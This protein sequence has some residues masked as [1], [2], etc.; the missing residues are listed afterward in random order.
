MMIGHHSI[1]VI[2]EAVLKGIYVPR[3]KAKLLSLLCS[4]A[5]R[6]SYR[7]L[8]SYQRLGYVPADEEE[9]SVSKTLEYAYDD[10]AIARYA[11]W[12]GDDAVARRYEERSGAWRNVWSDQL[13]FF[14]P[15]SEQAGFLPD[16]YPFSFD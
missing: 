4:T 6:K 16:F 7:G 10:A 1:P 12:M 8:D 9:E 13:G 11:R 3:D 15:R 14:A 5:E 2:V